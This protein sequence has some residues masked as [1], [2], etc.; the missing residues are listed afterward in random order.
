LTGE[1]G[2]ITAFARL[3]AE[4]TGCLTLNPARLAR[5]RMHA[6]REIMKNFCRASVATAAPQL[7]GERAQPSSAAT[8]FEDRRQSL[9]IR[10][11]KRGALA[12]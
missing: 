2:G 4:Q 3:S 12:A 7:R 10:F 5:T 6:P 9:S 11:H 1:R 8:P